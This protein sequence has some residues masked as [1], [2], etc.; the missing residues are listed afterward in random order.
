MSDWTQQE[1]DKAIELVGKKASID[2]DFRKLALTNPNEAIKKVMNK[3]VPS[4]F[5]L[6]I[7]ENVPGIDQTYVLPNM[8]TEE[9]SDADLDA[10][11]GGKSC[12]NECNEQCAS[13][14]ATQSYG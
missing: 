14:C 9:L 10:V 1:V 3:E 12:A 7:I 11:A 8:Q 4:G 6:K 13:K 5:K 2:A